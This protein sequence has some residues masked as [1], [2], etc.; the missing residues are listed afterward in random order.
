MTKPGKVAFEERFTK[1]ANPNKRVGRRNRKMITH[2]DHSFEV[3]LPFY[4]RAQRKQ[5]T[6]ICNVCG[7]SVRIGNPLKSKKQW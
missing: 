6:L 7:G 5:R 4:E 1:M 2:N 3:A